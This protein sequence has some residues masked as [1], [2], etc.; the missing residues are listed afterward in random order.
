VVQLPQ[1]AKRVVVATPLGGPTVTLPVR[2]GVDVAGT[3]T[4]TAVAMATTSPPRVAAPRV[5]MPVVTTAP[6]A[7]P[8][9]ALPAGD[10]PPTRTVEAGPVVYLPPQ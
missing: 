6:T 2:G 9:V 10:I 5:E 4:P 8:K 7:A 1:D 3:P